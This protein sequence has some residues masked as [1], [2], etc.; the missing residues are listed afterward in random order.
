MLWSQIKSMQDFLFL[1]FFPCFLSLSATKWAISAKAK[2]PA[3]DRIPLMISH[4]S[5]PPVYYF[6]SPLL[7]SFGAQSLKLKMWLGCSVSYYLLFLL[8]TKIE[9]FP[10]V[11]LSTQGWRAFFVM[12]YL[13]WRSLCCCLLVCFLGEGQTGLFESYYKAPDDL[14]LTL[15]TKQGEPGASLLLLHQEY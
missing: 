2:V 12:F 10:L 11:I 1:F 5:V 15:Q 13:I 6:L 14:E 3:Q 9:N 7:D 8:I 4:I